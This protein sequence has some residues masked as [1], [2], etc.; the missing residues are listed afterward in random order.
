MG[1]IGFQD[2][3]VV[4]ARAYFKRDT[5]AAGVQ[6]AG[7]DLGVIDQIT[8]NVSTEKLTLDDTDGG[9]K[10]RIDEAVVGITEEYQ[11]RCKNLSLRNL[12]LSLLANPASDFTQS[13][14]E[15]T[16]SIR[17]FPGQLLFTH[18][19]DTPKTRLFNIEAFGG[20]YTGVVATKVL[21]SIVKATK[22]I[23][24]TGDQTAVAGLA[25]GKVM[26]VQRVGL[27]NVKNSQAYTIVTRTLNGGSTDFVVE[28]EPASDEAAI[29]G[30]ITHENGGTVYK[31]GVDFDIVS[32]NRGTI[33]I[34][35]G[36]LIIAEQELSAI[37]TTAAISGKRLI[38]PQ[39]LKGQFKG[40]MELWF[41]RGNN[42]EQTVREARVS[43]APAGMELS[44][45]DFGSLSFTATVLGD[46]T[47]TDVA[48]R[49]VHVLGNVP[50]VS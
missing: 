33:R 11:I 5:D 1:V 19:S 20:L 41:G 10:R 6:Y 44:I 50:D 35:S 8:P 37:F 23:K 38:K 49:M 4:G 29:T 21:T 18:D 2:F 17:A 31:Q 15:K 48:G 47:S 30:Q 36:G 22:T 39:S 14:A 12:A 32:L 46:I 34:K 13:Q 3:W 9:I 16:V 24:I 25:P 26:I 45:D 28:Q 40:V 27:T 7:V 42:A 43:L